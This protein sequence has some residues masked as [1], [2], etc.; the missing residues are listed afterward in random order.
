M[1]KMNVA[2]LRCSTDMQ[3]VQHQLN[4]INMY[5]STNNIPIDKVIKDEGISAYKTKTEDRKGLMDVLELADNNQIENLIVFESSRLSRNFEGGINIISRLTTCGVKIYSV[6]DNA[7]INQNDFDKL[8]NSFRYFMNEKASKESSARIKSAKKL[9]K[10]QGLYMGGPI[11]YGYTVKDHKLIIDE[12]KVDIIKELYRVYISKS[13][14]DAIEYI[15]KYTDR[16]TTNQTLVQYMSNS[17][18]EDIVGSQLYNEYIEAKSKR[19][20]SNGEVRT[21]RSTVILEG[22]LYHPCGNKLTID[23]GRKNKL[24]FRCRRCKVKKTDDYKKSYAGDTLIKNIEKEILDELNNLNRERLMNK[25]N[26]RT[27]NRI[28]L[29]E[30]RLKS[31][32]RDY[33]N[34]T[35][36]VD[37]ANKNLQTV[38]TSDMDVN[39]V[40][41]ITNV[42]TVMNAELEDIK[43]E[44]EK[45]KSE[46][47][48]EKIQ[49]NNNTVMV[50]KLMDVKYLYSKANNKQRKAILQ[51]I[52]DKIIVRDIDDFTIYFKY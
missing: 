17:K 35:K 25:Y 22:L 8:M 12:S 49:M 15:S 46:I 29:V 36:E 33:K 21:N 52:I 41:V 16:Y 24:I 30:E 45:A 18:M 19:K 23:Y 34:K 5:A 13:C 32:E 47:K 48:R 42:I 51:Q 6:Q 39:M 11:L 20:T 40:K 3:D 43:N 7:C 2:Y 44:M 4:S 10:E 14:V 28:S 26:E 1:K 37:K 50:E 38:L 9:A 27:S 31:L